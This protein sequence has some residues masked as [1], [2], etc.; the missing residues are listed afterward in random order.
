[1]RVVRIRDL[2]TAINETIKEQEIALQPEDWNPDALGNLSRSHWEN[3]Q[4]AF[5]YPGNGLPFGFNL[6][7]LGGTIY[8]IKVHRMDLESFLSLNKPKP[9][10][11]RPKGTGYA[12]SDRSIVEKMRASLS[13]GDFGTP[14]EA[15]AHFA[16]EAKGGG[17]LASKAKRLVGRYNAP[18]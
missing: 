15:A 10:Q 18:E 1:M 11:G 7:V 2:D 5:D 13:N 12:A 9:Q 6:S 17:T 16:P 8:D 3:N 14:S 4:V